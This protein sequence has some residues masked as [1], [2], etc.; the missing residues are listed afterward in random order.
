[1]GK[2]QGR[3]GRNGPLSV[4]NP[5]HAIRRNADLTRQ[6]G[7]GNPKFLEFLGE[8]FAGVDRCSAQGVLPI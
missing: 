2:A 8:M 6:L 4:Q 5:G 3:V 1:M 7:R